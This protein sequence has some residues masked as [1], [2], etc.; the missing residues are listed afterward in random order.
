M[1]L[2][3]IV[4]VLIPKS[5]RKALKK[6]LKKKGL[7]GLLLSFIKSVFS[8]FSGRSKSKKRAPKSRLTK[9]PSLATKQEPLLNDL[10]QAQTYRHNIRTMAER[11]E[12]DS[13]ERLRLV[14]LSDRV[15]EWV[16]KLEVIVMRVA[17][18]GDDS[19]LATERKLVPKAIKRLDQQL[20]E[21]TD[22]ELRRK[23]E[24]TLENRRKQLA[25]LEQT[26]NQRKYVELKVEN[27]LAQLGII[28]AQLH[29]GEYLRKRSL[30]ERMAA[31]VTEEVEG[32]NNYL[33]TLTELQ[34]KSG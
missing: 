5:I 24:K 18:Q 27:T 10:A 25:Q 2:D 28:Y 1:D 26:T 16:E 6:R 15:T 7:K 4:K 34:G 31:D 13:L 21:T 30:Y 22:A 17:A 12:I 8:I 3:D 29:S 14:Q 33:T 23:L 32:L 20:A 9:P 19:L 11:A